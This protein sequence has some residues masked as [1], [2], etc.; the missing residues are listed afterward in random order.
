MR[1]ATVVCSP[2]NTFVR[3]D[4]PG[5]GRALTSALQDSDR[6]LV[7]SDVD[8][9]R[10]RVSTAEVGRVPLVQWTPPADP[11]RVKAWRQRLNPDGA[12]LALLPGQVRADKNP[13]VFVRALAGLPGWRGAIV[14][15]DLGPGPRI[16]AL[17]REISA[18]VVTVYGYL[19]VEDFVALVAAADV[20]AAPYSVASQSGVL[21][22]AAQVGVPTAAAPTGG[23]SEL[24][25]AVAADA[26]PE[27]IRDALVAAVGRGVPPVPAGAAAQRYVEEYLYARQRCRAASGALR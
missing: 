3:A 23:L 15:D 25:T 12:I 20:V 18:P 17:I 5:G 21:A 27:A 10:V 22:V 8:M 26:G 7:Y 16:D 2:H 14:G 24:A 4:A 11:E 19:D 6:V 1:G 9:E 13:D